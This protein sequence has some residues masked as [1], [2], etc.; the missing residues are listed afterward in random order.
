M[1]MRTYVKNVSKRP[2]ISRLKKYFVFRTLIR[3]K[4]KFVLIY[5]FVNK[6]NNN[7]PRRLVTLKFTF[8]TQ[9]LVS[10]KHSY[11]KRALVEIPV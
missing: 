3:S 5:L 10:W 4:Q 2:A 1:L 9:M 6:N 8:F 11:R 7:V